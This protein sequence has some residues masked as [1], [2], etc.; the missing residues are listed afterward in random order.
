MKFLGGD[1]VVRAGLAALYPPRCACCNRVLTNQSDRSGFC[2]SCL[3][4]IPFRMRSQALLSWSDFGPAGYGRFYPV[5]C[6]TW[7][8][9]PIRQMLLKLKFGDAPDLAHALAKILVCGWNR[10]GMDCRGVIAVP[11]HQRRERERGYNQA[12]LIAAA[13]A[14]QVERPDWSRHLIRNRITQRQSS[15]MT[16]EERQANLHGAFSLTGWFECPEGNDARPVVLVD[17]VLTT[18]TTLTEAAIPLWR[19]NIPVVGLVVSSDKQT[20]SRLIQRN[21]GYRSALPETGGFGPTLNRP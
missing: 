10:F 9:D 7:Y 8:R 21:T 20:Q 15:L 17:D 18:G 16:R 12:G 13:F 6:A 2:R 11:L 14:K 4:R 1:S 19:N 5:V 3:P